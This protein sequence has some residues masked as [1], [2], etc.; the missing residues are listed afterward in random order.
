M[1]RLS[2]RE[3]LRFAGLGASSLALAACQPKVVE[4]VVERTVVVTEEKVVQETV[5]VQEVVEKEV[6]QIVEKEAAPA[7]LPQMELRFGFPG[8]AQQFAELIT[9]QFQAREPNVS[10]VLEPI[11]GDQVQKIYTMAAGGT[12][13][14]A[15]WISD[16]HAAPL[17]SEGVM[18][19]MMPLAEA[20]ADNITEDMYPVM[21]NLGKYQ[22][23]WYFVAWAF[24]APV[25]Y[26]NKTLFQKAGLPDPDPLGMPWEDWQLAC[27]EVTDESDQVYGWFGNENWWAIYVPWMEGFGGR[28]YSEDKSKVEINSPEAA[29]GCQALADVYVKYNAAV[30]K[31]A[32]L[33]GDPFILG[34]AAMYI[35]N[36]N[37]CANI[38]QAN[39]QFEWDVTLAPIQAKKHVCGSGTM[40]PG[41]ATTATKG[42]KEWATWQ[43]VK[44][45]ALPATQKYFARQYMMIPVLKSLAKDPSWYDLPAP[46][47]NRDVFL[48]IESRAIIPPEPANLDC[49]TVYIGETVKVMNEAWEKMVIGAVPAQEVLDEAAMIINDCIERGGA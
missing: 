11:A 15:L 40:G 17:G 29:A 46:P 6:T 2:R 21:L 8:W 42:G 44:T 12:T 28:F 49:G 48:E 45:I 37:F 26:Y 38:R 22:D 36:R 33:G 18:L 47:A 5:V 35:T 23:H 20:D 24:D 30:P 25:M 32:D 34:K 4:K 27:A 13:P 19:D 9:A 41:I 7:Q 39:V 14:E 31:G 10:V 1:S 3:L 43:L 16:A